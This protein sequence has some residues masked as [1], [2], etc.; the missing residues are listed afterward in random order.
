MPRVGPAGPG[1]ISIR[2][3]GGAGPSVNGKKSKWAATGTRS[4]ASS[5]V[6]RHVG[7]NLIA[8]LALFVA[9]SG[10]AYAAKPLVT[11]ADIQDNTIQSVDLQDG[12]VQSVDIEAAL[13]R[14]SEIVPTVL[15]ADGAGST[16]DAD[17]LD[18][19][20]STAFLGANAKAADSDRLDG[21]DSTAFLG[22][23]AKAANSDRLD[24][25]DSS[26]LPRRDRKGRRLRQARRPGLD[27][28]PR[29]TAKAANS[30]YSTAATPA[31]SATSGHGHRFQHRVP[32]HR[33]QKEPLQKPDDGEYKISFPAGTFGSQPIAV[34]S[35][36]IDNIRQADFHPFFTEESFTVKN[37]DADGGNQ[38]DVPFFLA[39]AMKE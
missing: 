6:R 30:D 38:T 12:G 1:L 22:A 37:I 2:H 13:A 36:L 31:T 20:D 5:R 23:T 7:S 33:G 32:G 8:Y 39:F 3:V 26:A 19:L 10:S 35:T 34:V 25:L 21:Q 16:L 14:D 17:V 4:R 27:R 9:L 28:L 29:Q 24:G 11:S 15:A 18:G